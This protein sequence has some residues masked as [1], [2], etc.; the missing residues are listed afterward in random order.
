MKLRI[1]FFVVLTISTCS[2][3]C[4]HDEKKQ[5]K[6]PTDESPSRKINVIIYDN[7]PEKRAKYFVTELKKVIPEIE[8]TKVH[9]PLPESAWYAPRKRYLAIEILDYMKTFTP[10]GTI[11]LGLTNKDICQMRGETSWGIMGLSYKPG[12]TV[13][14]ST[15]RLNKQKIDLQGV[16]LCLHELGHAE[17]LSHCDKAR[18]CTMR[19]AKGRNHFDELTGF[20]ESCSK[21]LIKKGWKL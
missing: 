7:F 13:I 5:V 17:G 18:N 3:S 9:E 15:F 21:H 1:L 4:R 19:D 12:K 2:I 6:L 10:K 20:C 11:S 16:K 8:I 14:I